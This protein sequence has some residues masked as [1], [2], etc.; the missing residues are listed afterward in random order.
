MPKKEKDKSGSA[1]VT[2]VGAQGNPNLEK[3]KTALSNGYKANRLS[4]ANHNLNIREHRTAM[5]ENKKP[6][7]AFKSNGQVKQLFRAGWY[8]SVEENAMIEEILANEKT[9]KLN[10]EIWAHMEANGQDVEKAVGSA[11]DVRVVT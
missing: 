2:E 6:I 10:E 11:S 3:M 9:R 7:F 5:I 4:R 1:L 8:V